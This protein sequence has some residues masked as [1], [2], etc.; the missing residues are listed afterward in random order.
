MQRHRADACGRDV[1]R[2]VR[3]RPPESRGRQLARRQANGPRRL[4]SGAGGLRGSAGHGRGECRGGGTTAA[5][6]TAR[7]G[8]DEQ[9]YDDDPV[10]R[11]GGRDCRAAGARVARRERAGAA[12]RRPPEPTGC[13]QRRK[14]RPG[15]GRHSHRRKDQFR[16]CQRA[17]VRHRRRRGRQGGDVGSAAAGA[18]D[19]LLGRRRQGRRSPGG[20]DEPKWFPASARS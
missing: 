10:R 11:V 9:G 17:H 12:D 16:R 8:P 3:R 5:A 2:P 15:Q 6:P 13:A 14:P 1:E 4:R 18:G 20:H 19:H 7:A